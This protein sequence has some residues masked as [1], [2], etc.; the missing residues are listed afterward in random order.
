MNTLQEP[1]MHRPWKPVGWAR[2]VGDAN[3]VVARG[4]T[5]FLAGQVGW[6]AEGRFESDDPPRRSRRRCA[7]SLPS[8]PAKAR[9]RS[10]SPTS[11][12]T[13][14]TSATR[15]SPARGRQG[16]PRHHGK[17]SSRDDRR[18]GLRPHRRSRQGR[19]RGDCGPAGRD[20]RCGVL[21]R[22]R[23]LPKPALFPC[24]RRPNV[25]FALA[26]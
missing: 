17:D 21:P 5:I 8:S 16:L 20:R 10:T 14:S 18:A 22:N 1:L 9:G 13:P 6:N 11:S 3:G 15:Q 25:A 2:S 7:T 4:R 12:G 19:N 23:T 24:V 26:L